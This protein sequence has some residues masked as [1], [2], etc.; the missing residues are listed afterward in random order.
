MK[1]ITFKLINK[2]SQI[3]YLKMEL[4]A[5]TD[6]NFWFKCH[7]KVRH[8]GNVTNEIDL[9]SFDVEDYEMIREDYK[10]VG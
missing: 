5:I 6:D 3:G 8:K 9:I 4:V 10:I 2:K 1:P 7:Y